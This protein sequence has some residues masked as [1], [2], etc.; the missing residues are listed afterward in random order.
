MGGI[1]RALGNIRR[2]VSNTVRNTQRAAGSAVRN[3]QRAASSAV[4]NT[5]QAASSAVRNTRRAVGSTVRST[6]RAVGSAVRNA[7][8]TAT[9]AVRNTQRT[10]TSAVRN[11]QRAVGST[12]RRTQQAVGSTVRRTQQAVR[13]TVRNVRQAAGN[14]VRRT[15]RAAGNAVNNTR[16]AVGSTVRRTQQA[17]GS[18]VRRTQRAAGNALRTTQRAAGN[19]VNNTRRAVGSTVRRTQRA[20]GSAVSNSLRTMRQVRNNVVGTVNQTRRQLHNGINNLAVNSYNDARQL[21]QSNNPVLRTVGNA[22]VAIRD[23]VSAANRTVDNGIQLAQNMGGP[24]GAVT[25]GLLR[26][27]QLAMTPLRAVD[28][29]LINSRQLPV[30]SRPSPD[31]L[32]STAYGANPSQRGPNQSGRINGAAQLAQ[33]VYAGYNEG[34]F[35][36]VSIVPAT[37]REGNRA[38]QVHLVGISGTEGVRGQSTGWATNVKAGI[39]ET[40]NPGLRNARE[41]ILRTVPAGSNLVLSGH[42]QGGMLAQQLAADPEIQQRYNVMN[43]VTFGSPLISP[44]MRA[45]EVRRIAAAGD[46]VPRA[47]TFSVVGPTSEWARRGQQ[48]IST[49]FPINRVDPRTYGQGI[50]AHMKDYTNERNPELSRM[51]ALGRVNPQVPATIEFNPAD[52]V[53]FTSPTHTASPL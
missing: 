38:T 42:S 40:T 3:T 14:T 15:Q 32:T 8:R 6:Q 2:T 20:T 46:P 31:Q 29:N 45:G 53:F 50:E 9:S 22:S 28:Q 18:T 41:A 36:P 30:S 34:K 49:D 11:T 52:R 47:S 35:G 26:A 24:G 51:D 5:R 4:R 33:F 16:R 12:V 27:S 44:G 21:Q 7:Q 19:A 13:S 17:V 37:V 43:T 39:L 1:G 23:G 10:A 48:D 25:E